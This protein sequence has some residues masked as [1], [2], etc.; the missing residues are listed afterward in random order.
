MRE[1]RP[2]CSSILT[3]ETSSAHKVSDIIRFGAYDWQVLDFKD[4]K[5]L[6]LCKDVIEKRAYHKTQV[7]V[8][9]EDCDVRRYLKGDFFET[10]NQEDKERIVKT[11]LKNPNN[12]WHKTEG[13][14]DTDDMIF[15]LSLEE[16]VHY[17]G[18]S[19]YL[20]DKW[21]YKRSDVDMAYEDGPPDSPIYDQYDNARKAINTMGAPSWWWLRSP[22]MY[23]HDGANIYENGGLD[24]S[25]KSIHYDGGVRPALWLL[26]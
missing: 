25:G 4:D 17:F 13:G 6:L 12:E 2:L 23:E 21:D 26:L 14:N 22:G 11:V 15:L 8:T 20:W 16:I 24:V 5:I 9:W 1:K 7:D 3:D 18:D 19:G 10:F